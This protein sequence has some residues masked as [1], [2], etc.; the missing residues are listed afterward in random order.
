MNKG[1]VVLTLLLVVM[2]AG[3]GGCSLFTNHPPTAAFTVVYNTDSSNA[4]VVVLDAS[5]SSD[6]DGDEIVTYMWDFG[7]DVTI[8]TPL[9]ESKTVHVPVLTV[10]YPVEGTYSVELVVID[11]A[12]KMSD[13]VP[14]EITVPHSDAS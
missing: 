7:E 11:A 13:P 5:T 2:V 3:A 8:L 12:G 14:Q 1:R 4:L 9:E 6:P 10:A